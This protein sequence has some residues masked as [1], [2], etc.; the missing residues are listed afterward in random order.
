MNAVPGQNL[1]SSEMPTI[2]QTPETTSNGEMIPQDSEQ[3]SST[4]AYDSPETPVTRAVENLFTQSMEQ[5]TQAGSDL[6]NKVEGVDANTVL[7][8]QHA[9]AASIEAAFD[10]LQKLPII[11]PALNPEVYRDYA[12]ETYAKM[13]SDAW[14]KN[15][16][17]GQRMQE[18]GLTPELMVALNDSTMKAGENFISGVTKLPSPI[19]S[20]I[21][22]A[23]MAFTYWRADLIRRTVGPA[24][25][26][27][28]AYNT[29][30]TY[31]NG[32]F[33]P[34]TT[35]GQALEKISTLEASDQELGEMTQTVSDLFKS[36]SSAA[37]K[38][39]FK[40]L[41]P[42]QQAQVTTPDM[43]DEQRVQKILEFTNNSE[44]EANNPKIVAE[45][46]AEVAPHIERLGL[47]A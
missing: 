44:F 43:T 20:L 5:I 47:A 34:E 32:L 19:A 25:E 24:I 30:R 26:N 27:L 42:E 15:P 1:A 39:V 10:Q 41:N 36:M 29:A 23:S 40:H 2:T 14:T 16:D 37:S 8:G 7:G 17:I 21:T 13:I 46:E 6:G 9:T 11:G 4:P 3:L 18:V 33:A 45:F 31:I 35:I 22:N 12:N 28:P 38:V